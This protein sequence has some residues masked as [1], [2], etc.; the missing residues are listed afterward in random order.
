M[1]PSLGHRCSTPSVVPLGVIARGGLFFDHQPQFRPGKQIA[2]D[3]I[4]NLD[5]HRPRTFSYFKATVAAA[6][7]RVSMSS[8]TAVFFLSGW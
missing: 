1:R 2:H 3:Q 5:F 4:S 8:L 7:T 6:L